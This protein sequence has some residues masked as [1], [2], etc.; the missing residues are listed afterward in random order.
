MYMCMHVYGELWLVEEGIS[1]IFN[2]KGHNNMEK[3]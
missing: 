3:K 2:T 1:N